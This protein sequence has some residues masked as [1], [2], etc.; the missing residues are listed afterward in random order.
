MKLHEAFFDEYKAPQYLEGFDSFPVFKN[1][2]KKEMQEAIRGSSHP[3]LRFI[4]DP[5]KQDLYVFYS[6]V[7]HELVAKKIY[8]T[9]PRYLLFGVG[10][11]EDGEMKAKFGQIWGTDVKQSTYYES[12]L[13]ADWSWLEKYFNMAPLFKTVMMRY[14]NT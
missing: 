2:T 3:S 14:K 13:R 1:P 4:A 9:K 10:E 11:R 7:L 12:V 5:D 8:S 6:D